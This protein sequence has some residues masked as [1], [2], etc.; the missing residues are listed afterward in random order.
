VVVSAGRAPFKQVVTNEISGQSHS[1]LI[2][3]YRAVPLAKIEDEAKT[4][5][6]A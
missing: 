5:S 1:A 2:L 6:K 3:L 4:E